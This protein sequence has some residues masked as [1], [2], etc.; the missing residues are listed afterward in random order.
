MD[1]NE[2]GTNWGI[3]LVIKMSISTRALSEVESI[4][5]LR[6]IRKAYSLSRPLAFF[7]ADVYSFY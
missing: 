6:L 5:L 4:D 1:Q 3:S 7:G 2:L